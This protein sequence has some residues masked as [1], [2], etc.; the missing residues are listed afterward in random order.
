M[1]IGGRLYTT[2]PFQHAIS[3]TVAAYLLDL[4]KC[5][6]R[7]VICISGTLVLWRV[8]LRIMLAKMNTISNCLDSKKSYGRQE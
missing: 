3:I 7:S 2:G 8:T 6:M 4:M 5:L 1:F